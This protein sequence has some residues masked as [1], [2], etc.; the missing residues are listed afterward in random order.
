MNMELL[1]RFED[2]LIQ[3]GKSKHTIDSY[4][5]NAKEYMTWVEETFGTEFQQ[6]FR[7][8]LLEFK[9]YLKTG[10]RHKGIL[11]NGKTINHK[12]CALKKF[13]DF[14]ASRGLKNGMAFRQNDF[15]RIQPSYVNPSNFSKRDIELLRQKVLSKNDKRLYCLITLIAYTGLRI[16]EALNVRVDDVSNK[17]MELIVRNGKGE[18]QRIVYINS[19]VENAIKEYLPHRKRKSEYLFPSRVSEKLNRSVVNKE[20]KK[21]TQDITPH[22]LRHFF[23]TNA[24][25]NGFSIHEVAYLAGHSNPRTTLAYSRPTMI[26]MKR[27]AE[28]L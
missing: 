17:A 19:K 12:L 14:L 5:S 24:L 6:F 1:D 20:F 28:M 18:K 13:N 23:C 11:I 15:I 2:Y 10:K 25:E 27:K 21:Y 16:S 22:T 8:N 7:E 26:E 4:R 3:E 9:S